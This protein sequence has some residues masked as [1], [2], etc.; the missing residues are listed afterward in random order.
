MA[1]AAAW[2]AYHSVKPFTLLFA[3]LFRI[4]EALYIQSARQYYRRGA[5]WARQWSAS[6]FIHA[7]DKAIARFIK[8]VF[9]FPKVHF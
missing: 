8:L 2:Y 3:E 9:Q 1:N 4:V 5:Y 7:A 6:R